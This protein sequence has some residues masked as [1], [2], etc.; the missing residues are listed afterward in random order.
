MDKLKLEIELVPKTCLFSN[1]RKVLTQ[2]EWDKV[3][4]YTYGLSK[5]HSCMTCG[6]KIS[7]LNAHE[8]WEYDEENHIQKLVGLI[9]LCDDCHLVKHIGFAQLNGKY[10]Q[11]AE[12]F[13]RIN[14]CDSN[15]FNNTMLNVKKTYDMR[16]Q[17][18][19]WKLDI[20]YL[21]NIG[22]EDIY[23]KYKNVYRSEE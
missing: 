3:R 21:K 9:D 18:N 5:D 23:D 14:N 13:C 4:K 19:D 16:S 12:H 22:F 10:F 7:R 11:A 17:I 8:I 6:T 1:L 2:S 15:I 20:S